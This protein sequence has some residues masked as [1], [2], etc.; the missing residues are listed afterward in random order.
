[1]SA[2][3]PQVLS[4][5]AFVLPIAALGAP[6]KDVYFQGTSPV[7]NQDGTLEF[8]GVRAVGSGLTL[9]DALDLKYKF[10]LKTLGFDL[11]NK[12]IFKNIGVFNGSLM[13]INVS[14]KQ[15]VAHM[16]GRSY[17]AGTSYQFAASQAAPFVWT[18]QLV[19]GDVLSWN[20]ILP[21]TEYRTTFAGPGTNYSQISP[22]G[23]ST[24]TAGYPIL[25]AGT[26]TLT[27]APTSSRG[28]YFTIRGWN[29][30]NRSLPTLRNGSALNVSFASNVRDYVKYAVSLK[31]GQVLRLPLSGSDIALVLLNNLGA[32]VYDAYGS[33]IAY[34]APADGTYYLFIF[35]QNGWGGYYVGTA[36]ITNEPLTSAASA[37]IGVLPMRATP[38][39]DDDGR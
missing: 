33:G 27:I 15:P 26:Y 38:A 12:T 32:V 17:R 13:A 2:R 10:S 3:Y 9:N 24:I 22:A 6:Y 29:A 39:R 16:K 37:D 30:N 23:R 20:V 25:K 11:S 34:Q 5:I 7:L 1:M 28:F 21:S 36:S 4:A 8:D 14:P 31:K 19:P 35:N 18:Y